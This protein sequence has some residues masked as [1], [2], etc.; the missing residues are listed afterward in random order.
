M[1]GMNGIKRV[2]IVAFFVGRGAI[3][4]ICSIWE[5]DFVKIVVTF[6]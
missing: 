4:A 1:N 2:S 3:A 6:A 5:H